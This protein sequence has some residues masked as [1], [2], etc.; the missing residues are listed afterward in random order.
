MSRELKDKFKRLDVLSYLLLDSNILCLQDTHLTLLV[1]NSLLPQF[2][3]PEILVSDS[4][5]NS[6]GVTI[7]LKKKLSTKLNTRTLIKM[8]T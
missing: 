5:T 7:F 1:V 3:D 2:P 4:K 8:V 6:R